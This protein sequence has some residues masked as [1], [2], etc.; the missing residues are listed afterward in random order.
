M[1]PKSK[2]HPLSRIETQT[3]ED[4]IEEA[5]K[6][7]FIRPSTSPAVAGFFFG[8]L[9]PCIDYQGLNNVTVKFRYA[10]PLVPSDLEQHQT[11]PAKR[12]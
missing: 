6:S 4:Y 11:Q 3:M 2:V 5:L 12:V 10:L 1:P 9:R 8:G 7:S